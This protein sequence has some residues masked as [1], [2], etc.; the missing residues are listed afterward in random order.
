MVKIKDKKRILKTVREIKFIYKGTPIRLPAD[1]STD[2]LQNRR[3]CHDMVKVLKGENL[4]PRILYP[5]RLSFRIKK[6]DKDI[7]DLSD[8][9]KYNV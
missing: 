3:E 2:I 8:K 1:F 5:A 7:K 4:Q 9:K 6:I